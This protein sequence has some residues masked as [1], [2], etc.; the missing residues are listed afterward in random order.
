MK[1]YE[2]HKCYKIEESE[3]PG[4]VTIRDPKTNAVVDA[5]TEGTYKDVIDRWF[6]IPESFENDHP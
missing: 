1:I 3:H 2:D 5:A 4:W 6:E